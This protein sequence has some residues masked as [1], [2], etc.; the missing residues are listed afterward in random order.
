M[1][2]LLGNQGSSAV[3]LA[4]RGLLMSNRVL[5][6]AKEKAVFDF[7]MCHGTDAALQDSTE[8]LLKPC[9]M[10]PASLSLDIY[11]IF[12]QSHSYDVVFILSKH[13]L[14]ASFDSK[15]I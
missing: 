10:H 7:F 1:S 13:I 14:T 4:E 2:K 8:E 11:S 3:N 5:T 9:I 6:Q 12:A 15:R